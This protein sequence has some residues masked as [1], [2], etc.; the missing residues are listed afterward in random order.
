MVSAQKKKIGPRRWRAFL[1]GVMLLVLAALSFLAVRRAMRPSQP[2][3]PPQPIK[4]ES[5]P[6]VFATYAG[7]QSCRD[8]HREAFNSWK[9]SHHALAER[10][11][12]PTLDRAAFDPPQIFKHASQTSEVRSTNGRFEIVTT[13]AGGARAAFPVE[14]VLGVAPLKQFLIPTD[15]G[16]F[17]VSELAVDPARGDWFD[18]FGEENRQPGEWGHWTGRGMTWNV[19]CAACHNT[20]VR[21]NYQTRSDIYRTAMAETGVGCEACHGPMAKHVTWQTGRNGQKTSDPTLHKLGKEQMLATCGSCHSRRAEL[22]G[23][24]KPGERFFDH[25]LLSIPDE[26]DLFYPDGQI[27][28]EDYEYTSFLSSR[29]HAAGVRCEDCHA[30]HSGRVLFA[31]NNLC[32]RCHNGL[33]PPAPKIDPASHSFHK[34]NQAGDRCVD[35]HMPQTVYM[36]RHARRDHG[37][38]IP[39]PLLTK[40]HGIPNACNRCHADR[41]ADWALQAVEKW[42][43]ARMERPTRA[44]ARIIAEARAGQRS[45]LEPL[46][47]LLREEKIPLWRAAAADL[48]KHWSGESAVTAALLERTAD[49]DPLVRAAAARALEGVAGPESLEGRGGESKSKSKIKIKSEETGSVAAA[50]G[51]LLDDPVRAVR[52]EAGWSLRATLATNS[53]AG[54]DL[55]RSLANNLDQPS[56]SMQMGVFLFD[57]GENDN[58]LPY[59]RRAV[60]WDPNSAPLHQALAVSLSLQ[61]NKEEVIKELETACRLAPNESEYRFKLGLALNEAGK[62]TEAIRA[63]EKAVE[64][65]PRFAQAWYNLGL[66]ASAAGNPDR[67][68]EAL[69]RA[70]SI[71]V[72][73][74]QIPYARATV[75]ARMGRTDEARVAA[76]RALEIQPGFAE[77]AALLQSLSP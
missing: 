35:C 24:F 29:M 62:L 22:T 65:E 13:G 54:Q 8:C 33:T 17:Q 40:Q 68:L 39:D 38:T 15:G 27:H 60:A 42:Y 46:L 44:R 41:N 63:L 55:L 52:V 28:E 70:E 74:A 5:D 18:V 19:M 58:A 77:A 10:A 76:G 20:R 11:P 36:Q 30:P 66:A 37:F 34:L 14:R 72:A 50:L 61:D 53:I 31:D 56:G 32:L 48:L 23:D 9:T 26:T 6:A 43:G 2:S 1:A 57:R 16:R 4:I 47:R 12:E 49:T 73:A 59:F 7:S 3:A 69:A 45:A 67:A 75:L 21:K 25:Y 71:D 51:R 64:L